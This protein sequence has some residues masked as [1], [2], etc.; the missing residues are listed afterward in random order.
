MSH[1]YHHTQSISKYARFLQWLMFRLGIKKELATWF[2][3]S[4]INQK[5]ASL[6]RLFKF[7]CRHAYTIEH[8]KLHNRDVWI[9]NPKQKEVQK[10]I[11]YLHGGAYIYN[12][13][14]YHW[15]FLSCLCHHTQARIVVVDYPLAPTADCGEAY[16]FIEYVYAQLIA[17]HQATEVTVMGD[18]AGGGLA[19]GFAQYLQKTQYIQ[20]SRIIL[21]APWLDI[22]LTHPKI[23]QIEVLDPLLDKVALIKAGEAYKGNY[24]AQDPRVSPLYGNM[25]NLGRISIFISTH[26]LLWADC[27]VLHH[28]LKAEHIQHDYFEYPTLFHVWMMVVSLKESRLALKQI[29]DLIMF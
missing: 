14:Q 15:R 17:N 18:S 22:A 9:L 28:R 10:T 8:Q 29:T 26:D 11:F 1:I 20:P 21:L 16:L 12:I 4:S 5:A 19:L 24:D 6:P 3:R 25:K 7:I 2:K 23:D 13:S 27:E